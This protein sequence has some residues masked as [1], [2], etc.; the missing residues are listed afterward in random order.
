MT[1]ARVFVLV[2]AIAVFVGCMIVF[3]TTTPGA[4]P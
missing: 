1:A 3:V 2:L 4:T